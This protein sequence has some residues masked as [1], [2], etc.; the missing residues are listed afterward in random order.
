[1]KQLISG[2][3]LIFIIVTIRGGN[4][5]PE[6]DSLRA[7]LSQN[8]SDT[9]KVNTLIALSSKLFVENPNEAIAYG[10]EAKKLSEKLSY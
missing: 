9:V 4:Y 1:M 3:A 8:E 2:L 6:V 5:D 10:N 7:M